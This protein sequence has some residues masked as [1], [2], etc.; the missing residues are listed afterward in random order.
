MY[1]RFSQNKFRCNA[2]CSFS[3]W[4]HKNW[5]YFTQKWSS[6][7]YNYYI[8]YYIDYKF[9]LSYQLPTSCYIEISHEL[10]GL[11]LFESCSCMVNL[12]L[13]RGARIMG[14]H[15]PAPCC[16]ALLFFGAIGWC[17]DM[18]LVTAI[19]KRT[20]KDQ[21]GLHQARRIS[22][23]VRRTSKTADSNRNHP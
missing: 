10:L 7:T 12:L 11:K 16:S 13:D 8:L 23:F 6:I 18:F 5:K 20:A 1:L 2:T 21:G 19:P 9:Q 14:I 17:R 4:V 15:V 22:F 3:F